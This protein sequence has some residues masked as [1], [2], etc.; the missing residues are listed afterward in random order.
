MKRKQKIM[1]LFVVVLLLPTMYMATY[2]YR[3]DIAKSKMA[4]HVNKEYSENNRVNSDDITLKRVSLGWAHY[5][6]SYKTADPLDRYT[7]DLMC[8]PS[9]AYFI[10]E[11]NYSIDVR[12]TGNC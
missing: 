4:D 6:D 1:I 3:L 7:R 12:K 8:I 2:N 10:S 11:I 9:F 5:I